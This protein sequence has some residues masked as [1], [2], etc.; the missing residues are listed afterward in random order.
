MRCIVLRV[1]RLPQHQRRGAIIPC[2]SALERIRTAIH[3]TEFRGRVYLVGG[4][5]RDRLLGR[6][7]DR[8][9]DLVVVGDAVQLARILHER[10]VSDHRP[11][12][13]PRFGTARLT[14]D[15][16]GVELVSARAESY[17]PHSRKPH[18]RPAGLAEDVL[19]RDF[20]INTL[21]EGLHDGTLLDLTGRGLGDLRERIIRTPTSPD[22]TFVDDPLRMLRAIR[23]AVVLNFAI[24]DETLA[25][26]R[27]NAHRIDLV[28][29]RP[30]VVSAERVRDE[31][32][33]IVSAERL[34]YGMELLYDTGLLVRILP[35]LCAMKG[36]QQNA[37][38]TMDVWDHTMAALGKLPADAGL[39]VRLGLLFHDVGKPVT[40]S[41]DDRGVHFYRHETV[42]AEMTEVALRRL[43]Y[44]AGLIRRV[45]ALVALHMRLGQV[46][47]EWTDGA[48]R[49][50]IRDVGD[51]LDDLWT[52][53]EADLAATRVGVRSADMASVRQRID[54]VNRRM[55]V[56]EVRSP[57]SGREIMAEL[58]TGAG[59]HIGRAKEHLVNLV[60]DGVLRADDRDAARLA[61]RQ[62]WEAQN[63][64]S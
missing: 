48:V 23:F 24:E 8:D 57:L 11:V 7:E 12:M 53:A 46:R 3:D 40:V 59:E 32:T 63:G 58:G 13:Y 4:A 29:A 50:L 56:R 35:E 55:N 45:R 26:I 64:R 5:I 10:G 22:N 60:L 38:H 9:L 61:L 43:R 31:F 2:V 27:R 52:L 37:W 30:R 47:P 42:G 6:S 36:V 18:V 20:T 19:R 28:G 16:V 1:G 39:H 21:M 62:W 54:E 33:K 17:D 25:A 15:G 51:L 14:V 49:R 34:S 41:E 44:S